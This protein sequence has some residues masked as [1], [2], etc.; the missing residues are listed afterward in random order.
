VSFS[1]SHGKGRGTFAG[2]MCYVSR[3]RGSALGITLRV[4]PLISRSTAHLLPP[5]VWASAMLAQF[6]NGHS[7]LRVVNKRVWLRMSSRSNAADG[8]P[9]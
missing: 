6:S 1:A 8:I 9:R 2:K 4:R 5:K 3:G 7:S